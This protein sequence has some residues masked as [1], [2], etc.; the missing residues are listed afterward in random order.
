[1]IKH[2]VMFKF[3]DDVS[4]ERIELIKQVMDDMPAK[5]PQILKFETG[6]DVKRGPKSFDL[7]LISEFES[8]D[9]LEQYRVHPAHQT[10][11]KLL[12]DI[13]EV[14]YAVDYEI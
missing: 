14:N 2:I 4:H 7:V 9:T 5:I 12:E 10:L 11:I 6:L 1:M 13:K 8:L 3:K